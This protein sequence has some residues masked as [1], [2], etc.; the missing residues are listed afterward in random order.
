[1]DTKTKEI[2]QKFS[3]QKVDLNLISDYEKLVD[4]DARLE[5]G[6]SGA[7]YKTEFHAKELLKDLNDYLENNEKKKKIARKLK[8]LQDDLGV[9]IRETK[10]ITDSDGSGIKQAKTMIALLKSFIPKLT[11]I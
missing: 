11:K 9:Q 4:I 10:I 2:L 6:M 7:I 5:N 8:Q 3:T 1:M